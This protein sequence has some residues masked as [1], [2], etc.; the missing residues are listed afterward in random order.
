[1]H[2]LQFQIQDYLNEHDTSRRNAIGF[3]EY[4]NELRSQRSKRPSTGLKGVNGRGGKFEA[5]NTPFPV[6]ILGPGEC[7][8]CC[9]SGRSW[10]LWIVTTACARVMTQ[11]VRCFFRYSSEHYQSL[12]DPATKKMDAKASKD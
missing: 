2:D 3:M 8:E 6:R 9:A 7:P 4:I 5:R 12:V 1:V 10:C 11:S